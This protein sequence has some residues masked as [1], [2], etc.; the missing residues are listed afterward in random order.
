METGRIRVR[1]SPWLVVVLVGAAIGITFAAFSTYD[2]VQYLDRQDHSVT[3][4]FNPLAGKDLGETG[5]KVAMM[6]SYSSVLRTKVWG[7][8]P[9]ALPALAVFAFIGLFAIDL[10]LTRRKNDPRATAFLAAAAAL[11]ALV[12]VI[13]LYVSLSKLG[14]TCKLCVAIYTASALC[15]LGGIMVWREAVREA[16]LG[17]PKSATGSGAR[18]EAIGDTAP[19]TTGFLAMA[20][21]IGVAFVLIPVLLYLSLAPD[22]SKFIGTC[23]GLAQPTDTYNVMV[24]V[25][26]RGGTVRAIEL[27]DPLCPACKAFEARLEQSGYADKLARKAIL[28]PLDKPCNWMIAEATH[29]GACTVSE[30][31]LCAG[32]RAP[33]VIAW[34]FQ[35]QDQIRAAAKTDRT[36]AARFVKERFPELASCVGS[37]EAVSRLNQSLRWAVTNNVRVLTP[38]LYLVENKQDGTPNSTKLCD[39]DVDLGLDYTLSRMID[40]YHSNTLFTAPPPP[41]VGKPLERI[42]PP[43]TG[44]AKPAGDKPAGDKPATDT[45]GSAT[46][47]ATDATGSAKPPTDKPADPAAGSGATDKPPA[48]KPPADKPPADKP[49]ADKPPA[50]KPAE[51]AAPAPAPADD[52]GGT[53]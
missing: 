2:F 16:A 49:P 15:L 46:K 30:A 35:V 33:D 26:R 47:P 7:G 10:L 23:E 24:P 4:S 31:V 17:T 13:M 11:P 28:F 32:D 51:P 12:S 41:L 42:P 43:D 34:A 50:D 5:C 18:L 29:P 53:Q 6:S 40:R 52:K 39:E 36:A 21:G 45:A 14:T 20:F 8:V 37:P 1:P 22:H 3:C 44:S 38:Q 27:L 25:D 19:A 9:I 48:D